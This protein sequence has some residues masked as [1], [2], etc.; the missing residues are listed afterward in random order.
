MNSDSA[1]IIRAMLIIRVLKTKLYPTSP[2][3][4]IIIKNN[5]RFEIRI[6]FN[7][8]LDFTPVFKFFRVL[9]AG[10]WF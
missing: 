7:D 8:L 4:I 9:C 1:S 2:S 5:S 10:G 6:L 3:L